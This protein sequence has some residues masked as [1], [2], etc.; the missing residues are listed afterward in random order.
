MIE[1]TGNTK[2]IQMEILRTQ[3]AKNK[4]KNSIGKFNSRLTQLKRQLNNLQEKSGGKC[5]E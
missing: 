4:T 3:N 2:N 1:K 5:P